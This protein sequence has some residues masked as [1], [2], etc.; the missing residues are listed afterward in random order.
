MRGYGLAPLP[1]SQSLETLDILHDPF[2]NRGTAFSPAERT[3]LG[4]GGWLPPAVETVARF[5]RHPILQP[6][7]PRRVHG[8]AGLSLVGGARRLRGRGT[9]LAGADGQQDAGPRAG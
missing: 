4:I 7:G 8:G 3:R 1:L 2:L 5:N 6:H 9:V